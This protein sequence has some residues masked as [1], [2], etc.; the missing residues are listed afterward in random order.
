MTPKLSI[1]RKDRK[2]TVYVCYKGVLYY[3]FFD[4]I[5]SNLRGVSCSGLI[6]FD[7]HNHN[8]GIRVDSLG[9]EF[10]KSLESEL[11]KLS[12]IYQLEQL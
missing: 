2:C 11:K 6:P 8:I 4:L 9:T 1:Y 5:K 3:M 7:G 12:E 10:V